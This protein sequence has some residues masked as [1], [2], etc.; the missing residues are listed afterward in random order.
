[1]VYCRGQA[2]L[3]IDVSD[4]MQELLVSDLLTGDYTRATCRVGLIRPFC[5]PRSKVGKLDS[6]KNYYM[7]FINGTEEHDGYNNG[8]T[9]R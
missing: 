9:S 1:M 3:R 4:V 6:T 8:F 7:V 2:S 5:H